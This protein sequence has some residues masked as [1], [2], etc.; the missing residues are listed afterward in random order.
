MCIRDRSATVPFVWRLNW[1]LKAGWKLPWHWNPEVNSC[2]DPQRSF[3][4]C[5]PLASSLELRRRSSFS[6]PGG[7]DPDRLPALSVLARLVSPG[8]RGTRIVSRAV[9]YTH[10]RAHETP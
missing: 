5:S 7:S 10:L 6:N 4:T 8:A 3:L 9:S 2:T 1:K